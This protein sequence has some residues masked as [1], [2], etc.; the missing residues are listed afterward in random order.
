MSD[1]KHLDELRPAA[2]LLP[3]LRPLKGSGAF[4]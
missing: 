4:V 2:D 1:E 3:E